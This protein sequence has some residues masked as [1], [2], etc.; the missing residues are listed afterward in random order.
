MAIAWTSDLD[1][2][3]DEIDKQH[4]QIV[5]FINRLE[6]AICHQDRDSVGAVLHALV[7]YCGSHFAFEEHLQERVGYKLAQPH[8]AAH[9]LFVKRLARYQ[10]KHNAG[11]DVAR[12][13]H[14]MLSTWLVHHIKRDDMGYV[15]DVKRATDGMDGEQQKGDWLSRSVAGF[16]GSNPH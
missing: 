13:L 15:A 11:E 6:A 4:R 1:T 2:G 7:E 10:E 16:F 12:Q 5:D 8:K 3:I 14:D 9:D